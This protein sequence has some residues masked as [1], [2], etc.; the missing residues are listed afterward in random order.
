MEFEWDIA[1]AESNARKHGVSFLTAVQVFND[2][3]RVIWP[4][5]RRA[6]GEPR[7]ITTGRSKEEVITVVYTF[8]AENVRIISARKANRREKKSYQD[9]P[10]HFG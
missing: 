4:D 8:R 2:F 1:K 3:Y 7:L 5:L 9:G 6:Y 10:Y